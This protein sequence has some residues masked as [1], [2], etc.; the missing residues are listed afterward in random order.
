[1]EAE[2]RVMWPQAQECWQPP[3]AR[4]KEWTFP[5][6]FRGMVVLQT[7][8]FSFTETDYGVLASRVMKD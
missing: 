4:G 3:E 6:A 7:L 2:I 1:M 5:R 8:W